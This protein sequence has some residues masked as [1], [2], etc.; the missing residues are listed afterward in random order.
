[1]RTGD[2]DFG[3]PNF[4]DPDFGD[5]DFEIKFETFNRYFLRVRYL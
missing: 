1:M 4:S 3:D 5:P 2:P